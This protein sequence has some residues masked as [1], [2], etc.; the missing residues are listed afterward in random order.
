M[1]RLRGVIT[2]FSARVA[3]TT[4]DTPKGANPTWGLVYKEVDAYRGFDPRITS[5]HTM[6]Q[7]AVDLE[8]PD[9][10]ERSWPCQYPFWEL[11]RRESLSLC[12]E[13]C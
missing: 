13:R 9:S 2:R 6:I 3:V 4:D 7:A 5:N 1:D 12:F 8:V 11:S 10:R